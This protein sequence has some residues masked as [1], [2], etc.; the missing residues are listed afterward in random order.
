M[1][2]NLPLNLGYPIVAFFSIFGTYYKIEHVC[3]L[4]NS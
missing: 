4:S 2:I 3:D 1:S